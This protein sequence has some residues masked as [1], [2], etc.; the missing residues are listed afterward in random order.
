MVRIINIEMWVM[1]LFSAYRFL[2]NVFIDIICVF[3]VK[4]VSTGFYKQYLVG[5]LKS[6]I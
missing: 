4:V 2:C 6:D 3:Y 5:I 1:S